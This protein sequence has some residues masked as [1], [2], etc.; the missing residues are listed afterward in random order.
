MLELV[1][2]FAH[3]VI[4]VKRVIYVD[5]RLREERERLIHV[6]HRVDVAHL[7]ALIAWQRARD[8]VASRVQIRV[9]L[10]EIKQGLAEVEEFNLPGLLMGLQK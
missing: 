6:S 1:A 4:L 2:A 5:L 10:H 7:P 9:I 8:S 3:V